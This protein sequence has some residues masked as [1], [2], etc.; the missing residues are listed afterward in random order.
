MYGSLQAERPLAS[1]DEMDEGTISAQNAA[2]LIHDDL[3][4]DGIPALNLAG[5]ATTYMEPVAYCTCVFGLI[6]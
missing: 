5:F 6:N 4:L 2:R 3:L 1:R